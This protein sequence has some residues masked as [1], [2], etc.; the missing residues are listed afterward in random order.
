MTIVIDGAQHTIHYVL[1]PCTASHIGFA[2][3]LMC[4][5]VADSIYPANKHMLN[6]K[7]RAY[8]LY[9]ILTG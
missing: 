1:I 9:G 3:P 7:A 5:H 2:H 4:A 8:Q 6:N